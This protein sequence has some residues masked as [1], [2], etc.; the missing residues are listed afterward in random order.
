MYLL[1]N[2]VLSAVIVAVTCGIAKR[3]TATALHRFCPEL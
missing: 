1:F 2:I 3:S